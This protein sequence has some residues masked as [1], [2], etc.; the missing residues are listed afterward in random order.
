[1]IRA[2]L[3]AA[4]HV[5]SV[6]A[7]LLL[8]LPVTL[9]AQLRPEPGLTSA[10]RWTD[11]TRSALYARSAFHLR[12]V[13]RHLV[14][15]DIASPGLLEP[16]TTGTIASTGDSGRRRSLRTYVLVGAASGAVVEGTGVAISASHCDCGGG[17]WVAIGTVA[18]ALA[19][20]LAGSLLYLLV[21]I[22]R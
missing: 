21:H 5:R 18:G 15:A 20:A 13:S 17:P 14:V 6:S 7:L 16:L 12:P 10:I 2:P 19:G 22:G 9:N 8:L 3:Y 11:S 4:H 1:M